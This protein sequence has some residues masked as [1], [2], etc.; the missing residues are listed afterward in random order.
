MLNMLDD[1]TPSL[2]WIAPLQQA[3]MK[4]TDPRQSNGIIIYVN[5]GMVSGQSG[6][7]WDRL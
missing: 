2:W 1:T 7:D 6:D 5:K 4:I 3:F